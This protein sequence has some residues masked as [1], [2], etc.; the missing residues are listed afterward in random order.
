MEDAVHK[1]V[2]C[3]LIEGPRWADC[4]FYARW[5]LAAE[6]AEKLW[7]RALANAEFEQQVESLCGLCVPN[8]EIA[9]CVL[10]MQIEKQLN[11][12]ILQLG[13]EEELEF[14]MMVSLGFFRLTGRRYQLTIPYRLTE[15]AVK[16]A[17]VA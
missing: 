10:L 8:F 4:K 9:A 15:A 14:C 17:A 7:A 1:D 3:A 16:R 13:S 12:I 5:L 11:I 6:K 2:S